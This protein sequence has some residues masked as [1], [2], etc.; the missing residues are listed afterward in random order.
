MRL[1]VRLFLG[2]DAV[3]EKL[4]QQQ[5][6]EQV[7]DGDTEEIEDEHG[8]VRRRLTQAYTRKTY[9]LLKRQGLL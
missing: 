5:K 4:K 2:A 1:R 3:Y 7:D 8:N 6:L 9:E